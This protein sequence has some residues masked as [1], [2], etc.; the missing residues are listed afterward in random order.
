MKLILVTFGV[1]YFL[2]SGAPFTTFTQ[3]GPFAT[4][5][6]CQNYQAKVQ[7]QFGEST[8]APCYSTPSKQ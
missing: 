7:Q 3:V 5:L 4:Q 6:A 8:P 1:W 2:I